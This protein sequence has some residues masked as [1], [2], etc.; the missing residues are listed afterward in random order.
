[1]RGHGQRPIAG[2]PVRPVLVA[3]L[4]RALDQQRAKAGAVDEQVGGA[5]TAILQR[6]ALDEAALAILLYRADLALVP[7]HA[8]RLRESAQVRGI[9]PGIELIGIIEGRRAR[10]ADRSRAARTCPAWPRPRPCRV[11]QA[12]VA[13]RPRREPVL[14]HGHRVEGPAEAAE[15]VE[16]A[17]PRPRPIDEL[18]AELKGAL[19]RP[20]EV[21]LVDAEQLVEQPDGGDRRLADPDRADLLGFDQR[22]RAAAISVWQSA[23]AVIHP[24]EPPPTIRMERILRSAGRESCAF[25]GV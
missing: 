19:C 15:G 1:M 24:A 5:D 11:I 3:G 18:D 25:I 12:D 21:I 13:F 23:A 8:A 20:D 10:C 4:E 7:Y 17:T 14:V 9:Q 6:D 2:Q 22:D 16:I